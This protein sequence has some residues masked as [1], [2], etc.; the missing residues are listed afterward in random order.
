MMRFAWILWPWLVCLGCGGEEEGA[1]GTATAGL[2]WRAAQRAFQPGDFQR[3]RMDALPGNDAPSADDAAREIAREKLD[4]AADP[5]GRCAD[6]ACAFQCLFE[7]D[8]ALP[9]AEGE[10]VAECLVCGRETGFLPRPILHLERLGEKTIELRWDAVDGATHYSIYGLQW[11]DTEPTGA[12]VG[13]Y[14]WQTEA[15]RLQLTLEEGSSYSFQLVAWSD[16]EVKQ[17]SQPSEPVHVDL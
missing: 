9:L 4:R 8:L 2:D 5:C 14:V 7:D 11:A 13:S 1:T 3:F 16:G 15:T 12:A 17:R 6:R 10:V